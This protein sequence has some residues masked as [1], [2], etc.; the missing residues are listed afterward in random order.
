MCPAWDM[1]THQESAH[2]L[3]ESPHPFQNP[4][5]PDKKPLREMEVSTF[6]LNPEIT[7]KWDRHAGM[8]TSG[9]LMI[10]ETPSE[11]RLQV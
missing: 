7:T 8:D 3:E 6:L 11:I 2:A 5:G 1:T 10:F 9:G 4:Q